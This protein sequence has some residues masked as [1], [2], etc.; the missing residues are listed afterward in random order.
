MSPLFFNNFF[1]WFLES[2]FS[3][4]VVHTLIDDDDVD[5]EDDV[6]DLDVSLRLSLEE[7]NWEI[8]SCEEANLLMFSLDGF[9]SDILLNI[10]F[11][12]SL[13]FI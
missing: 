7:D 4:L 6:D 8:L 1:A 13:I 10:Q 2:P 5:N 3:R 12:L 11:F 9:S